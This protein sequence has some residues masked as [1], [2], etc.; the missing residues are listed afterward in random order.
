MITRAS[1]LSLTLCLALGCSG[2][3]EAPRV[4]LAVVVDGRGVQ[5]ASTDLGWQVSLERC[6]SVIRD[7]QFT[8]AGEFHDEGATALRVREEAGASA[9]AW[10]WGSVLPSAHA[11]PGHAGGGDIIGELPGRFVVDWCAGS[12]E[13]LGE[14]TLTVGDYN[15]ANFLFGVADE[16]DG[17]TPEEPLYGQTTELVGTASKGAQTIA[18]TAVVAQDEGREVVGVPF[19]L[20]VMATSA[21]TLGLQ[22]VPTDPFEGDTVF[23]G[24]DFAALDGDGDGAVSLELDE[25]TL[26]LLRRALQDHDYYLVDPDAGG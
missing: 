21:N 14:A 8:T 10:L 1:A 3:Q 4:T 7:L 19:E 24:I 9:L 13:P 17:I 11:H 12:N 18:F 25:T 26:N 6:R 2:S 20:D 16:D 22:L 23:D 5:E 15:G